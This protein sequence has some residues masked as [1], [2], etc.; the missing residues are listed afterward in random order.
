VFSPRGLE[1]NWN[2]RDQPPEFWDYFNARLPAGAHLRI[3]PILQWTEADIWAYTRREGIPIISLYLAQNGNAIV[4]GDRR[5]QR[6]RCRFGRGR[7]K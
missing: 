6:F 2:V 5:H 1:G 4:I 7:A 3:H